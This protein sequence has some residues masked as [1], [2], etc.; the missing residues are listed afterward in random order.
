MGLEALR[1]ICIKQVRKFSARLAN[2]SLL[3]TRLA[4][5]EDLATLFLQLWWGNRLL[6]EVTFRRRICELHTGLPDL[7][8]RHLLKGG[9]ARVVVIQI[10]I[11]ARCVVAANQGPAPVVGP[12]LV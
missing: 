6:Q 8:V 12:V 3:L 4:G 7:R 11:V 1:L 9:V 10:R 2:A 5:H